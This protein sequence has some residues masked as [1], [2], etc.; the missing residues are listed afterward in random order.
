MTGLM[1]E[2]V[3]ADDTDYPERGQEY[4]TTIQMSRQFA[5]SSLP[6]SALF[7]ISSR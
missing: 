5:E 3:V 6:H 2:L 1:I 4:S 7:P